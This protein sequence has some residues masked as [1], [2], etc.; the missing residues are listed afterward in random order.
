[1]LMG[2]TLKGSNE[3]QHFVI[4]L[5]FKKSGKDT[6]G[7]PGAAPRSQGCEHRFMNTKKRQQFIFPGLK[8]ADLG[9]KD[10]NDTFKQGTT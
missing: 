8:M 7:M 9:E 5:F 10:K 1:M 4:N 3:R 6:L 2:E